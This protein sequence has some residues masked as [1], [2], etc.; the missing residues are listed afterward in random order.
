M[1]GRCDID[2]KHEWALQV[3]CDQCGARMEPEPGDA[4]NLRIDRM[5]AETSQS[6]LDIVFDGP[7]GPESG[8]FIEVE[9]PQGR[10]TGFGEW[11]QR[12]DGYWVLRF[13]D[14]RAELLERAELIGKLDLPEGSGFG[15]AL[16]AVEK[17]R[18]EVAQ[19]RVER[20][21][22]HGFSKVLEK[23]EEEALTREYAARLLL[24]QAACPNCDGSGVMRRVV[25]R[26][27]GGVPGEPEI[28]P[29]QC[30][31]CHTRQQRLDG[32]SVGKEL[33]EAL[34]RRWG[35]EVNAL[36]AAK[37]KLAA[38]QPV[39]E[40][41][42]EWHHWRWQ[43]RV[44][45][46]DQNIALASGQFEHAEQALEAALLAWSASVKECGDGRR[47]ADPESTRA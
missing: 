2:G 36:R 15:D 5:L 35:E 39:L 12:P 22:I 17:L 1:S 23:R 21:A 25:I 24:E 37:E 40:A 28:E 19:A 47:K 8:R 7:P 43:R 26:S 27:I 20:D 6:Y 30:Q 31:W 13:D 16:L 11:M 45:R 4:K 9:D 46:S 41:V 42:Q 14:V 32:E 10:S 38:A 18:Y 3:V 29:E 33:E 44:V 34:A